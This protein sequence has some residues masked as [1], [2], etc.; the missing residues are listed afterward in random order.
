M[1][2]KY[3]NFIDVSI[4]SLLL[5]YF[6]IMAVHGYNYLI[7]VTLLGIIQYQVIRHS[8]SY[9]IVGFM[10]REDFIIMY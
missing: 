3:C 9:R 7:I 6:L 10:Q 8:F 1:L 5:L 2:P 4:E